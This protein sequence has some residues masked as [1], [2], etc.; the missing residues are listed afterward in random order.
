M[1]FYLNLLRYHVNC[2][3]NLDYVYTNW[4]SSKFSLMEQIIFDSGSE[5]GYCL[6]P[7]MISSSRDPLYAHAPCYS[8]WPGPSLDSSSLNA[9]LILRVFLDRYLIW[10]ITYISVQWQLGYST[11]QLLRRLTD[12]T[13]QL[14]HKHIQVAS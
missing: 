9:G 6:L 8:F 2:F 14:P 3:I 13:K 4:T 7:T 12:Y 10:A 5:A 11:T 1:N